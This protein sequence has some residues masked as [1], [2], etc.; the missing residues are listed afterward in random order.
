LLGIGLKFEFVMR[1][2]TKSK[3]RVAIG[4]GILAAFLLIWAELAVGLRDTVRRKL[5]FFHSITF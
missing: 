2:V 3:H 1:M 5:K 4:A